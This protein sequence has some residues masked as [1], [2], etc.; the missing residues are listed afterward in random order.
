[1]TSYLQTTGRRRKKNIWFPVPT[2]DLL[3]KG[4]RRITG[5]EAMMKPEHPGVARCHRVKK[6][7]YGTPEHFKKFFCF[8][9]SRI[10]KSWEICEEMAQ[11][12]R[13]GFYTKE[14][15]EGKVA[16]QEKLAT[17]T[18]QTYDIVVANKEDFIDPDKGRI[19]ARMIIGGA[20]EKK[21]LKISRKVADEVLSRLIYSRLVSHGDINPD[22][23]MSARRT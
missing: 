14:K 1:M 6:N 12:W 2:L 15:F 13:K 16:V 7:H 5:Y 23:S 10:P 18:D 17:L 19:T 3:P 8:A 20:F 21:Q 9:D 4:A 22:S 11:A